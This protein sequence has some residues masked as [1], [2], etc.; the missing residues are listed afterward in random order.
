MKRILMLSYL[1]PPVTDVGGLRALGFAEN[2][3]ACGWEPHV[4]SVK[5]PDTSLCKVGRS[6]APEGIETTYCKSLFHMNRMSWKANGVL[7]LLLKAVGVRLEG[8]VVHELFCLPDA[9]AGWVLPAYFAGLRIMKRQPVDVI[10]VSSK[11]FSTCL[12]GVFLKKATGK[13][14]VLDFRDPASFPD[15]LFLPNRF[16]HIRQR[17]VARIERF[18]LQNADYLLTTTRATEEEYLNRY[19][20]LEGRTRTIYNG[21]YLPPE[22]VQT[23]EP[24]DVFTIVYLGNFYYDLLASD[25]F[26]LALKS[27]VEK[28]GIPPGK[29]RFLYVGALRE[30]NW[31]D[32]A[33]RQYG[34]GHLVQTTGQVTRD[35]AQSILM[36]SALMLLRIVPPM[37]STKLF[38][39]LRDGVPMLAVIEKGEVADIIQAFS[40]SSFVVTDN[41]VQAIEKSFLEAYRLWTAGELK[42][43]QNSDYLDRFNKL[44]LTRTFSEVLAGLPHG[45]KIGM[46]QPLF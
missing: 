36:R 19:P 12:A 30:K 17:A 5:N 22:P 4:L 45:Q 42:R 43:H 20:F 15:N 28:G 23:V 24:F 39:G 41:S 13:P 11:P 35:E 16:G 10:Y 46:R 9:F 25:T 32:D 8:N 7:R 21:Y 27:V 40:P 18:V 3:P 37:I 6:G 31:L 2:L 1:F 34:I 26:F 29:I 33:C 14:L 38:E 44:A